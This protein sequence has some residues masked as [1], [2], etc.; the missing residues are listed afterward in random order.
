[1]LKDETAATVIP[2][3]ITNKRKLFVR[4]V[5]LLFE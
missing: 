2:G 4:Y 5:G 1:M 3:A